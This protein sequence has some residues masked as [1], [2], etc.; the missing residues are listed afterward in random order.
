MTLFITSRKCLGPLKKSLG[1]KS[2]AFNLNKS[3]GRYNNFTLCL[4]A[5]EGI[6]DL[7]Q[8]IEVLGQGQAV[9]WK[10]A[11]REVCTYYKQ[12]AM[13]RLEEQQEKGEL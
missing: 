5:N 3:Y 4:G 11:Y 6:F 13:V 7:T 2:L 1:L 8:K 9:D 12:L 10:Q